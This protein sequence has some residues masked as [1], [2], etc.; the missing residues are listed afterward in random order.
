MKGK[1]MTNVRGTSARDTCP[2][3][4][5]KQKVLTLPDCLEWDEKQ[6]AWVPLA[7]SICERCGHT[8]IHTFHPEMFPTLATQDKNEEKNE[9]LAS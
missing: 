8:T 4:G 5:G 7:A 6:Q 1:Q 9:W 3:C 2:V